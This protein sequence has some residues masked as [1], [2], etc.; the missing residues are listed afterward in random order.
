MSGPLSVGQ[1]EATAAT[2]ATVTIGPTFIPWFPAFADWLPAVERRIA[3]A[4]CPA[5]YAELAP[6]A[7]ISEEVGAAARRFFQN[8]ADLLPSEPFIYGSKNGALIAEC[9]AANGALT[10][11]ISPTSTTLFAVKKD[12]PEEPIEIVVK[13][14]SNRLREELKDVAQALTG[15]HEQ[16]MGTIR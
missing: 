2:P 15:A 4:T 14:D 5:G 16:A 10:T 6:S 13:R 12:D 11:V 8:A 9:S 7:W 1:E 3:A